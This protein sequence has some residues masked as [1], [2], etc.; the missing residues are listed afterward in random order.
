MGWGGGSSIQGK[1]AAEEGDVR[2]LCR[3]SDLCFRPSTV[4]LPA[5]TVGRFLPTD[6]E[7]SVVFS[8]GIHCKPKKEIMT[9]RS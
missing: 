8:T 4:T 6:Y 5:K 3:S 9:W 1:K 7:N 2:L